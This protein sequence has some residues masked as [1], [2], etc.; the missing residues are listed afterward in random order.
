MEGVCDGR[1]VEDDFFGVGIVDETERVVEVSGEE[2]VMVNV[3]C[4]FARGGGGGDNCEICVLG[5]VFGCKVFSK[6][7]RALGELT[8][9]GGWCSR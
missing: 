3:V 8:L 7:V 2:D 1:R 5:L 6:P 4:V 9:E